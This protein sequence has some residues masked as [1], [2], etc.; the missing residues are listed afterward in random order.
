MKCSVTRR[1][2]G[3]TLVEL[4]VVIAIIGVL[5]GLLLPA[6]QAARE[7]ARRMQCSNNMKQLGLALQ[8]Y[9]SAYEQFP[10]GSADF[11]GYSYGLRRNV[12]A[13]IF[14]LPFIEMGALYEAFEQEA[15]VATPGS[16]FWQS[17][18]LLDAGPQAAFL[19]PSAQNADG[20]EYNGLSKSLYVFC[21][22]DA[23]WHNA[24]SDSEEGMAI[25]RINSRSMFVPMTN[26]N[27]NDLRRFRDLLDGTSNTLAMSEVAGTPRDQAFV[28]G[29]VASFNGM[30]DGTTAMA[31]PC[32]TA[33]LDPNNRFQYQTGADC[34]R[35][36]L[37]GDGRVINTRF[38]T[39]LPP[40]SYSCAYAGNNDSWGSFSPSSE[41]QGGVQTLLFDGS[42][43]FV[44]DSI[45]TGNLNARQVT[46]GESPYGVWGAMGTKSGRETASFH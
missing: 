16:G 5:V 34:W 46:S 38:T 26:G 18:T 6:V 45:D 13:S 19:C 9:H 32:M 42:V 14:L 24:K 7:A 23:M 28:K 15:K 3:F 2:Q 35:G 29:D 20:T 17:Q 25:A 40:N 41:H 39:T 43:R 33:P 11:Y 10:P 31:G 4:L 1:Y 8:N 44:T 37:F 27:R 30:Y 12:G 36:L 21:I 22:G